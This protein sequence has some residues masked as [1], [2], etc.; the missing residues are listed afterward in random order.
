MAEAG[1][2]A[3]ALKSKIEQQLQAVHVD[4]EDMSGS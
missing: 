2:S 4:I 3:E 1:V